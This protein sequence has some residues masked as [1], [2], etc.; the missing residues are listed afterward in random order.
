MA[1]NEMIAQGA[2][3]KMPD[4]LEQYGRIAQ[5]QQAQNQNALAQYQ[6]NSAKRADETNTNFLSSLRAAGDDPA[7]VRQALINAGKVKEAGELDVSALTRQKTQND[8]RKQQRENVDR[9]KLDLGKNPSNE[10]ITA[11]MQDIDAD[12][13]FSPAAKAIAKRGLNEMLG[14][15]V[16]QRKQS[17][18]T[19]GMSGAEMATAAK[20]Q[21][22]SPGASL[23]A[24]GSTTPLYTQPAAAAPSSLA[25]LQSELAAL[26]PGDRRRADYVA[27]IKKETT[28]VAGTTVVL[29]AQEKAFESG[30][31][32]G[33]SKKILDSKIAA[34]GALQIL[35]TNDVGRSL[36]QS[37][38]ITGAGANFFVGLNKALKQGGIDFGYADAA[39]NSQAYGSAMAANV[40]QLIKQFGAGTAISDADR[41]YATKAAAG[42][43]SMDEAAIR[44]VLD[45]NDRASRNVIERHNKSV[46]G[47]KTNIP[48]EVEIPNAV[49][50]PPAAASQIP[51]NVAPAKPAAATLAPVDKQALD[52]ANAN[53][54]D[55]R[56]LQIKQRLGQ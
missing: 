22:V 6:I 24:P 55:P 53:P 38:A 52:W 32:A 41:A 18:L 20:P 10:N 54:K 27:A 39:A 50:P 14:M 19:S 56:S 7:K 9:M 40:G 29:P 5:I 26:P 25:R 11:Y 34:E 49:A 23:M 28:P 4:P 45:I 15:T 47:I 35:Q 17:L 37:G 16:D 51:T 21:V 3:F 46:R 2:Q 12:P 1:L 30:L 48:L 33:Q 36:L 13:T 42:E 44:K 43:I 31:G 8:I